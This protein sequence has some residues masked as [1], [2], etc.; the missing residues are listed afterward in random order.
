MKHRRSIVILLVLVA[1]LSFSGLAVAQDGGQ[2]LPFDLGAGS[3]SIGMGSATTGV[4]DDAGSVFY[5]PAGLAALEWQEISFMHG[6]LFESTIYDVG[7]WVSPIDGKQGVGIG[8]MRIGTGD[9]ERRIDWIYDGTFD[10]SHSQY[11]ISYGRQLLAPVAAGATLKIVNQSLASRSDFGVGLD[12]GLRF[13]LAKQVSLGVIGRN[14]LGAELQVDAEPEKEP[15]SVV[16]GLGISRVAVSDVVS[17]SASVD[18]EKYERSDVRVRGGGEICFLKNYALRAGYHTDNL[19]LGA[20]IR[21]GRVSIDYA[22]KVVEFVENTHF[23][24]LSFRV[25]TSVSEQ[26]RRAELA[27][28][29]PQLSPEEIAFRAL[30]DTANYHFRRFQLDSAEVY[31]LKALE[32]EPGNEEIIGTLAAIENTRRIQNEQERR[33]REIEEELIQTKAGF[34]AEAQA[35]YLRGSYR[36][37]LDLLGLIFDV[38]PNNVQ[39]QNL[40][41]AIELARVDEI[42]RSLAAGRKAVDEEAWVA[43]IESYNRVLELDPDNVEATEA[44]TVVLSAMDLPERIR[45]GIDLFQRGRFDAAKNRFEAILQ[46]RPDEPTALEY[47]DKIKQAQTRST[48]LADI[49]RDEEAWGWYLEGLRQMRNK[50]YD[51]A[52][53]SWEQVLGRYPN[54]ANTLN[55]IQQARLRLEA[56][57]G[58]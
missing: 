28:Q 6:A 10:Y 57:S 36:A 44:K 35:L 46:V 34:L 12:F 38:D 23:F 30:Q 43:A 48:T 20:G 2:E 54:N 26:R 14:L 56:E 37:A 1:W 42:E 51:L 25:G 47:L 31:F 4:S 17:L 18:V 5:N 29:V 53:K 45:L 7:L 32:Y 11:L 22:Y 15:W 21:Q 19:T 55:N 3:R 24:T 39:A 9:I 50:E 41:A 49:Q 33:L 16:G 52:I 58:E 13:D 8:Y 27:R 40:K